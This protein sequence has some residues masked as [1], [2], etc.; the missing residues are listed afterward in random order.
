MDGLV[1]GLMGGRW[2]S[3]RIEDSSMHVLTAWLPD[4]LTHSITGLK[5]RLKVCATGLKPQ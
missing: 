4:Y 5:P 1:D 2:V 3:E